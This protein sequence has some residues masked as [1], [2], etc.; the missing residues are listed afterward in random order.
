MLE[1]AC[2]ASTA[3]I[4]A[5]ATAIFAP[6]NSAGQRGRRLDA[7]E[8][9]KARGVERAHELAQLGVDPRQ[10]VERGHD[11]REEADQAD[12]RQLG[13]EA[14]AEPDDEQRGD[15]HDRD[16]LGGDEQ[17]VD[18]AAQRAREVHRD[19][20]GDPGR[21]RDDD[22]EQNLPAVTRKLSHSSA[23]SFHSAEATS[24][25]RGQQESRSDA[26]QGA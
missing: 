1:P 25:G 4:T 2:S 6:L 13:R 16:G 11:D 20:A 9:L 18:G 17:G 26:A 5:T 23:R 14:E 21:D 7:A 24:C 19:G 3:P 8:R 22:A 10:A 12:D 15:D